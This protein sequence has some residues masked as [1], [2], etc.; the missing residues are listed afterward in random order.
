MDLFI[1][2]N[3]LIYVNILAVFFQLLSLMLSVVVR[4]MADENDLLT[5]WL[6]KEALKGILAIV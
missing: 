2:H 1:L 3:F 4:K 5:T 6:E